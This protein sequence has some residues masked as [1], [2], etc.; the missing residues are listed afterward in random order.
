MRLEVLHFCQR[1]T[2]KIGRSHVHLQ[3]SPNRRSWSA[4]H[5]F[6]HLP[7]P[8]FFFFPSVL[9]PDRSLQAFDFLSLSAGGG[10]V[11]FRNTSGSAGRVDKSEARSQLSF[12]YVDSLTQRHISM[13]QN[14]YLSA[15]C[16]QLSGV[17]LQQ[18]CFLLGTFIHCL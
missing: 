10:G 15:Y 16:D 18:V 3:Y 17:A 6:F 11:N 13:G 4:R 1:T 14:R 9:I 5:V 8:F 7:F 2:L 12:P